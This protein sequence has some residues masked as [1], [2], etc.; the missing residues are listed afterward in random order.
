MRQLIL[1]TILAVLVLA[2][3]GVLLLGAFPPHVTPQSISHTLPNDGFKA[4]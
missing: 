1:I 3:V 2:G 4:R